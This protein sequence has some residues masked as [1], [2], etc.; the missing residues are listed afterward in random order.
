MCVCVSMV[1]SSGM[2]KPEI[3][4]IWIEDKRLAIAI[5]HS[6]CFLPGMG[7]DSI[8]ITVSPIRKLRLSKLK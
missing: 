7:L 5:K 1:E 8:I 2:L 3:Y 6:V 4:K